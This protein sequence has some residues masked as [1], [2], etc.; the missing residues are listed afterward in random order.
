MKSG[1]RILIWPPQVPFSVPPK[2]PKM[3]HFGC[4]WLFWGYQK[5]PLKRKKFTANGRK[6]LTSKTKTVLKSVN[7]TEQLVGMS[8][9]K[10]EKNQNKNHPTQ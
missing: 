1:L 6:G 2:K 9:S 4:F 3:G 5:F 7:K 8:K 10:R